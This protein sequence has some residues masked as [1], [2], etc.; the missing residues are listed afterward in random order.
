MLGRRKPE[1]HRSVHSVE[2]RDQRRDR[3][4]EE[5]DVTSDE[6][7][8]VQAHLD[9]LDDEFTCRLGQGVRT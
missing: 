1:Q 2:V 4:K 6:V 3:Q 7:G 9:R 8:G 5:Q